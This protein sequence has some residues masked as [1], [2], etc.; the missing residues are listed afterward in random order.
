MPTNDKVVTTLRTE[1]A[2]LE[3][4]RHRLI[5]AIG[6]MTTKETNAVPKQT[7]KRKRTLLRG[8]KASDR[9]KQITALMMSGEPVKKVARAFHLTPQRIYQIVP[10]NTDNAVRTA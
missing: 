5:A 9:N 7:R 8:P 10:R 2:D 4:R 3:V 6:A 1:L